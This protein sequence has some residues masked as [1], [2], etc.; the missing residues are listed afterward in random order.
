MASLATY[1]REF[2][3]LIS[4]KLRSTQHCWLHSANFPALALKGK[5]KDKVHLKRSKTAGAYPSFLNMKH[6]N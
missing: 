5:V 1:F 2:L 3:L 6:A 4:W